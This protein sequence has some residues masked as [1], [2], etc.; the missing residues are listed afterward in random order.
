[1]GE[2]Y[3]ALDTELHRPVALKFL[4]SEV[5]ADEKRMQRFIQEA[6]AASALNHPNIL[7]VHE[8][9]QAEGARFFA[10]EFVDGMTLR[11]ALSSRRM[12]LIE[13]LDVAIQVASALVAAHAA[14]IVHRDIKPENIMLRRDGYVK[15][16]DFGLAKLTEQQGS[17]V[18][19]EAATKALVH[20]DP[21]AVMGT[22]HY[23]SPEQA[24][25]KEVD[26]RTDIWS[27]GV[28]LYEM[29]AGRV[30]FAGETV[31]HTIVSIL[32]REPPPP[33]ALAPH[34]PEALDL[35][36]AQALAKDPDERWQTAKQMLAALKKIRQRLDSD[37]E[38]ERSTAP[39]L[40]GRG[41][42]SS[43]G[44]APSVSASSVGTSAVSTGGVTAQS[45]LA[46]APADTARSDANATTPNVS[47]APAARLKGWQKALAAVGSLIIFAVPLVSLLRSYLEPNKPARR[48]VQPSGAQPAQSF[49]SMKLTRLTTSGKATIAAI[50]PDGK[51]VVYASSDGGQQS[52]W[53]RQT[54]MQSNVQIVPPTNVV[55]AR[56]IFSP[57]GNYL[58]Y[59]TRANN[60]APTL[61]QIPVLGGTPRLLLTNIATYMALSPDATQV[62]FARD[63]PAEGIQALMMSNVDGTAERRL[64]V[65]KLPDR[66]FVLGGTQNAPAWSPDGKTIACPTFNLEGGV[67]YNSVVA[68]DVASGQEKSTTSQK[69]FSI[70]QLAWL[71]DGSGLLVLAAEQVA[72]RVQL[73]QLSYPEGEARRI[74]NDLNSY[75][76]ISLTA[77][78]NSLVTVQSEQLSSIWITPPTDVAHAK[79]I[80]NGTG[81]IDLY[82]RWTPAN[83]LVFDSNASGQRNIWIMDA[84]GGNQRQLTTE[85]ACCPSVSPDGSY[86]AFQSNHLG[87]FHIFR[88]DASGGNLKQLTN[89]SGEYGANFSPDGKWVLHAS[90]AAGKITLWRVSVDGGAP[91]QLT[92]EPSY[93]AH[94]SPDGKWLATAYNEDTPN[95]LTKVAIIPFDGGQ[96][97][98]LFDIPVGGGRQ[99]LHWTPDSRALI[100]IDTRG[101]VSNLW[102]Q[103]IDG[104]AP[105]Q[106]TDFK[107]ETIFSFDYSRDGK[108]LA[109]S[110]GTINNDVVLIKDFR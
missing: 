39:E 94:V 16:L 63:F 86:I 29:I 52:L 76:T 21:G 34:V 53:M 49:G 55:Y 45:T 67:A 14:G 65:R 83:K 109:V 66:A 105:K 89:G 81:R 110:R 84:D 57:D 23:M 35:F 68:I 8:I 104:G 13:V 50:S 20:T 64:A 78:S 18:D 5:A 87:N 31:S 44:S 19:T 7:T 101:G 59:V 97:V 24:R 4:R 6:R 60:V 33:S 27:L 58:F 91:Q 47:A 107:S 69:F 56:L 79:Q 77:D 90:R 70:G 36:V 73:W 17:L 51:Y 38:I 108:Q 37:A 1:M 32:E 30:P 48:V 41:G 61:Y 99:D 82:V 15:V 25:G 43:L 22:A 26:A 100:Y 93:D 85:S 12:N 96:P 92:N 11:E 80:T 10:T 3:R 40:L 72:G 42:A 106:L 98:K 54:A 62:V 75:Q 103:P 71:A 88:M 2:V 46:A 74:T 102:T 28:V 9:G 95:S